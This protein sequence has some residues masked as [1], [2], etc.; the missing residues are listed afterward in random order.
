VKLRI[1]SK[2][3]DPNRVVS[4]DDNA[5]ALAYAI[6]QVAL[7]AARNLHAEDFAYT[8]DTQRLGV[9]GEYLAFG[10]H[11]ADRLA[12]PH[13]DGDDRARFITTLG[14]E[15][16]RHLQRNTEDIA[17]RGEYREPFIALLN[18][19]S[20]EYAGLPFNDD[21]PGYGLLRS[22]GGKVQK[23][24]GDSQTNRWV[25]DQVMEIDAPNAVDH[26][27]RAIANLFQEAEGASAT[28]RRVRS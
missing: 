1:R 22:F 26:I 12:H 23:T 15:A 14:R 6:W 7:G 20:A 4:L 9:I 8:D 10:V 5:T 25:I 18:E 24:M 3:N 17:G 27:R 16:A 19:R 13:M 21:R 28:S 2:W 11:V